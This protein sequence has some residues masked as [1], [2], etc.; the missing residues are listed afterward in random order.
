MQNEPISPTLVPGPA[1]HS[2]APAFPPKE[3]FRNRKVP[4]WYRK[5]PLSHRFFD[6]FLPDPARNPL[7]EPILHKTGTAA[8]PARFL[9]LP[10]HPHATKCD[11]MRPPT[12]SHPP[13]SAPLPGH[14]SPPKNQPHK[15]NPNPLP[16]P[17][18]HIFHTPHLL[19]PSSNPHT[20][21]PPH[22][23]S[24]SPLDFRSSI[25]DLRPLGASPSTFNVRC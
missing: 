22:A 20:P 17:K 25:L 12:K 9:F 23:H 13:K 14:S 10:P 1:F 15:T 7:I 5:V 19:L 24:P 16:R 21:P 3:P 11:R 4:L 8:H 2:P 6:E 18:I